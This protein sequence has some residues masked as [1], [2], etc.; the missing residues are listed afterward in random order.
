MDNW[1]VFIG[2]GFLVLILIFPFLPIGARP[3]CPECGSRKIG[4]QKTTTGFR[5]S[6]FGG[7]G[8]GGGD[9]RV[10]MQYDVEYHCNDCQA[11]WTTTA[12]ETR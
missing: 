7:G 3:R 4:V 9:S 8:E 12:T 11:K 10:Q 2:V 6:D 5:T 1:L